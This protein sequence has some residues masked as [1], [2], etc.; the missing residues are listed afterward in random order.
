M[1][2]ISPIEEMANLVDATRSYEA[3]LTALTTAKQLSLKVLQNRKRVNRGILTMTM[4]ASFFIAAGD[5]TSCSPPSGVKC[6][7]G[8]PSGFAEMLKTKIMEKVDQ[9]QQGADEAM[10]KGAVAVDLN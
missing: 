9:L 5:W 10:R 1:P 2:N 8:L 6:K 4:D 3:N 7:E